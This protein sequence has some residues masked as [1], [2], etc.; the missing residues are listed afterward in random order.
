MKLVQTKEE[1]IDWE[2][3]VCRQSPVMQLVGC[4]ILTGLLAG[5]PV[6]WWL[7]EAPIW[8]TGMCGM[9]AVL[10]IPICVGE[11]ISALKKTNWLLAIQSDGIWL[12]LRSFR[13][14]KFAPALTSV[15]LPWNDLESAAAADGM[16]QVSLGAANDVKVSFLEIQLASRVSTDELQTA[17]AEE[18]KRRTIPSEFVGVKSH[19]RHQH[20]PIRMTDQHRLQIPWRGPMDSITP[21]LG[22]VLM[23]L[24]RELKI[25]QEPVPAGKVISLNHP[26]SS[27]SSLSEMDD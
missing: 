24:G 16:T 11:A 19:G 21:R 4:F 25:E 2:A 8:V 20:T 26:T 5:A 3:V 10:I 12:N 14:R 9:L 15:F 17:I 18:T 7:L 22:S 27:G 1:Q 23:E 6:M 13:N